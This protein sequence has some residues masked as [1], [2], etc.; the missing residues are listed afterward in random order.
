MK[1]AEIKEGLRHVDVTGE[2]VKSSEPYERFMG[3]D[4][5]TFEPVTY[6]LRDAV[7]KD[8]TGSINVRLVGDE[9]CEMGEIANVLTIRNCYSAISESDDLCLVVREGAAVEVAAGR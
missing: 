2:I 1:I 8:D 9:W 4:F 5:G 3:L 6:T 7:I